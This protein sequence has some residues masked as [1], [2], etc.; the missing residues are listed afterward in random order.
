MWIMCIGT[1]FR[2][3]VLASFEAFLRLSENN[4]EPCPPSGTPPGVIHRWIVYHTPEGP[5]AEPLRCRTTKDGGLQAG[6][7]GHDAMA[8]ELGGTCLQLKSEAKGTNRR[9]EFG[10]KDMNEETESTI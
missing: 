9:F 5:R 3:C 4:V 1:G 10:L 6:E 2:T 7:E 8:G